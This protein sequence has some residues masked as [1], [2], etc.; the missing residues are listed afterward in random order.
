V[1]CGIEESFA[2]LKL[3]SEQPRERQKP[4]CPSFND[5]HWCADVRQ[6]ERSLVMFF[7]SRH[8][9][10]ARD[11]QAERFLANSKIETGFSD[12]EICDRGLNARIANVDSDFSATP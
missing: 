2:D 12:S 1:L 3:R 5:W 7:R 9:P 8:S 11:R 6:N 4:Q 10:G